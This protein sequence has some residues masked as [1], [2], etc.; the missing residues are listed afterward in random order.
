MLTNGTH[1]SE[2][3]WFE[4]ARKELAADT[5]AESEGDGDRDSDPDPDEYLEANTDTTRDTDSTN[6][7][8]TGPITG[9]TGGRPD[10]NAATEPSG[11]SRHTDATTRL[12]ETGSDD[13]G[14]AE[15]DS[16][17]ETRGAPG[18]TGETVTN[19]SFSDVSVTEST[20]PGSGDKESDAGG[21]P[22]SP[23]GHEG[24]SLSERGVSRGTNRSQVRDNTEQDGI[25]RDREPE[26]RVGL[27]PASPE[28]RD[29]GDETNGATETTET[30]QTR[31]ESAGASAGVVG[32]DVER[33]DR[34]LTTDRTDQFGSAAADSVGPSQSN[35]VTADKSPPG[36]E[37]G[38][39]PDPGTEAETDTRVGEKSGSD[40]D[41][42]ALGIDGLDAM[43]HDGVPP[44]SVVTTMG[45]AGTGKTTLAIEF[46]DHTLANGNCGVYITL[47]EGQEAILAAAERLGRPFRDYEQAGNLVIVSIDPAEMA[48]SLASIRNEL[49]ELIGASDVERVVLDS[50]SLLEMMYDSPVERRSEVRDFT[51][52]L[53]QAGVTT[54]LTS[55]ASAESTYASRHGLVE[56]H[57][58]AV[59]VQ[60]YVRSSEFQET[61]LAIEIQKIRGA[62]HSR[63]TNPYEITDKGLFVHRQA[64]TT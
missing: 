16:T 9:S 11:E 3:D 56:H 48:N 59:F 36:V 18:S 40:P 35:P 46:L 50:V 53:K 14:V 38:T 37:I 29:T 57:S 25:D 17:D 43:V 10:E 49:T 51:Q 19:P 28:E 55:E 44:N 8:Q 22:R 33:G 52:S 63:E 42:V 61:R 39:Q 64:D 13:A 58:D 31:D 47:E 4:R 32:Q 6:S 20:D 62:D 23:T 12:T 5:D 60:Q 27:N 15:L 45:A 7:G 2:D 24:D 41:R 30:T 26:S 34:D 54:L 1:M 21:S